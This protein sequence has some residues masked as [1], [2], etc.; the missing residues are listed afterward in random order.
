MRTNPF[1]DTWQF[2]LGLTR[3]SLGEGFSNYV[4]LVLFAVLLAAAFGLALINWSA[5]P[6]QKNG[7]NIV[8]CICR[9]LIGCMWFHSAVS[10][11]PLP[12]SDA[13][14]DTIDH[15]AQYAAFDVHRQLVAQFYLP[16]LSVIGPLVFLTEMSFAVSLILG[17][18][19]PLFAP[20]AALFSLHLWLG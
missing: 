15:M 19:V 16:H 6:S 7:A 11:L 9:V 4:F 1:V 3:V 2:L 20:L 5:D 18:A 13:F 12:I 14:K 17:F 10:K 8:T